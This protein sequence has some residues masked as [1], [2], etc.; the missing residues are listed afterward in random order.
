VHYKV[1]VSDRENRHANIIFIV[2]SSAV[3]ATST[4]EVMFLIYTDRNF[5]QE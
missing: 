5:Q 2:Y 4:F 1:L 3:A